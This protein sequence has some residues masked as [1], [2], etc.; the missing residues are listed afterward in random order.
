MLP[1]AAH[2]I[3]SVSMLTVW[4]VLPWHKCVFRIKG[5]V[6]VL[7]NIVPIF[8]IDKISCLSKK[9]TIFA[10]SILT[11]KSQM[12]MTRDRINI[13]D[14]IAR[15]GLDELGFANPVMKQKQSIW[16]VLRVVLHTTFIISLNSFLLEDYIISLPIVWFSLLF[17]GIL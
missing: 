15:F 14:L 1:Y 2:D 17:I 13:E 6:R 3:E 9:N 10:V 12:E 7:K 8:F 16:N 11:T 5:L 4:Q